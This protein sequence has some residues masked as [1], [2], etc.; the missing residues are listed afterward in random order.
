MARIE[1]KNTT[2]YLQDGLSGTGAVNNVAGYTTGTTTMAVD[3]IV[4]NTPITTK[5]PAD[6]PR[7]TVVGS[8]ATHL[9]TGTTESGTTDVTDSIT[10]TPGLTGAV[11][12][13]AVITFLPQRVEIT[14]GEGNVTYTEARE[15]VYDLDRGNL[16]TV[17][18]GDDQPLQVSLA[19]TFEAITTGTNEPVSPHD[20]LTQQ[21]N[22]ADWV[23]S[24]SD[25]CEAYAIDIV[26]EHTVACGT[27]QDETVTFPEFRFESFVPDYQAASIAV[28]G[29]CKVTEPTVVRS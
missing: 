1:L 23:S 29:R 26:V 21:G 7:F 10:F 11:V 27:K 20:A 6:G 16:D 8:T 3:T 12:D 19:V 25:A 15:F 18:E 5:V 22:A 4:L 28:Q 13:D 17:R 24:G 2:I 14:V 9:I